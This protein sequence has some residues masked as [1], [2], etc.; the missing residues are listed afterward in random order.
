MKLPSTLRFKDYGCISVICALILSASPLFPPP[1]TRENLRDSNKCV[2][3]SNQARALCGLL[4]G[5]L[6]WVLGP[7]GDKAGEPLGVCQRGEGRGA[8]QLALRVHRRA[9]GPARSQ[10]RVAVV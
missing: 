6:P 5:L 4:V 8:S 10:G 1:L 9:C 7:S 3:A 2:L